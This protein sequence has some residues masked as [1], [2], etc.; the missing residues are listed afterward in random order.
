MYAKSNAQLKIIRILRIRIVI[1]VYAAHLALRMSRAY[2]RSPPTAAAAAT[3][4]TPLR[5]AAAAA[6]AAAGDS[7][8][9][10]DCDCDVDSNS[11]SDAA[12]VVW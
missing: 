2:P 8:R 11:D 5:E 4:R 3:A 1:S 12:R 7:S 10:S 6:E 9:D